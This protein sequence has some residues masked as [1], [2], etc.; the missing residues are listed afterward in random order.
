MSRSTRVGVA[1]MQVASQQSQSSVA[2]GSFSPESASP[3]RHQYPQQ[4]SFVVGNNQ[5]QSHSRGTPQT[6]QRPSRQPSGNGG[7]ASQQGY[8]TSSGTHP[9]NLNIARGQQSANTTRNSPIASGPASSPSFPQGRIDQRTQQSLQSGP[10]ISPP[11]R[12]SSNQRAPNLNL[13]SNAPIVDRSVPPRVNAQVLEDRPSSSSNVSDVRQFEVGQAGTAGG[14]PSEE[15]Q[16]AANDATI[17]SAAASATRSRRRGPGS[18]EG[19]Q[20]AT[21]T[22]EPGAYPSSAD[23]QS[24]SASHITSAASGSRIPK[25]ES[26]VINRVVVDDPAIDIKRAQERQLESVPGSSIVNNAVPEDLVKTTPRTRQDYSASSGS[27]GRRKETRFGEYIL[28][29]TLGEGE[30]GKVKLGWKKGGEVQVAI[31]LIRRETLNGNPARLPKI[32]REVTIL[33][34][35]QHPNIVRLHEM[36]ETPQ[37]IGIILEYASGGELFDYILTHRYLKDNTARKL[38]AQLVSGVGYL[39]KKGIVHRDLKLENLLLDQN[40][41]IVITDFGFANTFDPGDELESEIEQNLTDRNFVKRRDL[42]RVRDNGSRR[43]D[44]MA[45]SCGSPCYAAPELVVTDSLYTGRKVDVWSC[46]VILV[47]ADLCETNDF[48]ANLSTVRYASRLSSIR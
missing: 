41:N 37:Y 19:P 45:T 17:A 40:R 7:E 26:Q 1:K 15:E 27:A 20:R 43:G 2:P 33:R 10:P 3:S 12:T 36:I 8:Q 38:F 11:P 28:G 46:G 30:F 24:R 6:S 32:Y 34:G 5:G 4:T 14:Q 35:L 18:P 16:E 48:H 25:D 9:S 13:S 39:H 21:S 47:M 22:K 42:D 23:V 44:L 31:K 29:Q